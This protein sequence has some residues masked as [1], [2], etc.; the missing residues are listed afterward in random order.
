MARV[1]RT[2]GAAAASLLALMPLAASAAP[3]PTP[4]PSLDQVLA[5][6][7][8]GYIPLSSGPFHGRFTA[9]EYASAVA[10]ASKRSQIVRTLQRDGFVDGYGNTWVNRT[11][12]HFLIEV[13]AAFQGGAGA[14]QWL[15]AGEVAEKALPSYQ[16]P[17]TITGLDP[18]FGVHLYDAAG[19][20]YGDEFAFV[21]GNDGFDF[22]VGSTKD[23][24]LAEATAQ[25]KHQYNSAPAWT[26]PTSQW[27]ENQG[28]KSSAA[29][30]GTV[31]TIASLV[32]GLFI[33]ALIV[34][35]V[36]M[37]GR[38]R[39]PTVAL[40]EGVPGGVT[41]PLQMSPDGSYWWDGQTWRDAA[42]HVPPSAQR[43]SDGTLWWDGRTWRPVPPPP[44]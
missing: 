19:K 4:S 1:N 39:R 6:P 35:A 7:P 31:A 9:D 27:P 24:A 20:T 29:A 15:T 36:V 40:A 21:K 13:V 33:L 38:A 17:D 12:Q 43:S 30:F 44:A 28:A 3:T 16:R 2:L 8:V 5:A 37:I 34:F 11:S 42:S 10:D 25:A 23:D 14:R 26:I 32:V 22:L 18:Y 41:G